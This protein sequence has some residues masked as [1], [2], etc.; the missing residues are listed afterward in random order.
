VLEDGAA[1]L[2]ALPCTTGVWY[3]AFGGGRD[4]TLPVRGGCVGMEGPEGL[5]A[6][7]AAGDG[8][9]DEEEAASLCPG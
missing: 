3:L 5:R 8:A 2:G 7:E 6:G 9:D 4:A 1:C